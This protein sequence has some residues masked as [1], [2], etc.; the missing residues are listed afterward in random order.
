M[1]LYALGHSDSDRRAVI[2]CLT[3]DA[4][5]IDQTTVLKEPLHGSEQACVI[6][7]PVKLLEFADLASAPCVRGTRAP[8]T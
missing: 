4:S 3:L 8:L 1:T 2:L 7:R 5:A 6:L